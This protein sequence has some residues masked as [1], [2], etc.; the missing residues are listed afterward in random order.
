MRQGSPGVEEDVFQAEPLLSSPRA[1][2]RHAASLHTLPH[3]FLEG[4]RVCFFFPYLI[5]ESGAEASEINTASTSEFLSA[6]AFF[7]FFFP[8]GHKP[9]VH[10][11]QPRKLHHVSVAS[12]F[13]QPFQL[14]T[15]PLP[16]PPRNELAVYILY[17][18]V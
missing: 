12:R 1:V 5:K 8:A 18:N 6:R 3:P 15:A 9:S 2:R 7:L 17:I 16:P 14:L 4:E 13:Y 10:G 11:Q